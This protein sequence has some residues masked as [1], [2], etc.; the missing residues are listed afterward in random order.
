MSEEVARAVVNGVS[1]SE[2]EE[3]G[4]EAIDGNLVFAPDSS[5]DDD[6][7]EEVDK[8]IQFDES[9]SDS[10]SSEVAGGVGQEEF[11]FMRKQ[12]EKMVS[13]EDGLISSP[14]DNDSKSKGRTNLQRV[15]S[16]SSSDGEEKPG[17]VMEGFSKGSSNVFE[18]I[19]D[20][21]GIPGSEEVRAIHP[22]T[23]N[24]K[25]SP[26]NVKELS[27]SVT[28]LSGSD[29][30]KMEGLPGNIQDQYQ[31][32]RPISASKMEG[33]PGNIQDF[34]GRNQY[35]NSSSLSSSDSSPVIGKRCHNYAQIC[36][37]RTCHAHVY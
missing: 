2:E 26:D 23:S 19:E 30:G 32:A 14:S 21:A 35:H 8:E 4:D 15:A 9:G 7:E 18:E 11:D 28:E 16:L 31:Q 27:G 24:I 17:N 13:L 36:K 6:E 5:D 3:D 12:E 10:D 34:E 33:P 25:G 22:T 1:S 37:N 20:T 29:L